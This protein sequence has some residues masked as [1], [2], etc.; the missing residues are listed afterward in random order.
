MKKLEFLFKAARSEP[1]PSASP[2]FDARVMRTVRAGFRPQPLSL[3]DQLDAWFPRLAVGAVL[4]IGACL[5]ADNL[6]SGDLTSDVAQFSDQWLFP[7]KG[8]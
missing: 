6:G 2:G 7:V 4:V 8:F 1:P 5:L 3:F